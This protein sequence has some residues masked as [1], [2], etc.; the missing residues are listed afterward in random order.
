MNQGTPQVDVIKQVSSAN[1]GFTV[2]GAAKFTM[3][4]A[5]VYC[6]E[7]MGQAGAT[8]PPAAPAAP[9]TPSPGVGPNGL[10]P[11]PPPPAPPPPA[12]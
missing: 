2:D 6:P 9:A 12:A 10:Y 5:G 4:A 1:S 3:I 8:Q 11:E 7:H